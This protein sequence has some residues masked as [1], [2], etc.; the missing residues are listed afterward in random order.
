M[1]NK[2]NSIYQKNRQKTKNKSEH[3]FDLKRELGFPLKWGGIAL[4]VYGVLRALQIIGY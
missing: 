3:K 2:I 4:A 1:E